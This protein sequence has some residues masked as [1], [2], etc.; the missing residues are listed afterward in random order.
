VKA[1][2][3]T[4]SV[5]EMMTPDITAIA[6]YW[7]YSEP[8]YLKSLGVDLQKLPDRISLTGMLES[9]LEL[10]YTEKNTYC[11]IWLKDGMPIGHCNVN[12]IKYGEEAY[13]HRHL[14]NAADRGKGYGEVLL[15]KS[16]PCFFY[17]LRLHRIF[18][19]PYSLNTAPNKTLEKAGFQFIRK[20]KCIPGNINF[21]QEVNLW[22]CDNFLPL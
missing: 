17:N 19:Q 12:K 7:L 4:L 14:W 21:E 18:S 15:R 6:D 1:L 3:C 20:E 2:E 13:L 5:R 8:Q 10:N 22:R 16:I 9:Q 11:T